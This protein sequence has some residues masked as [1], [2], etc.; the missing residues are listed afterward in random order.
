MINIFNA[1]PLW[2]P[3]RHTFNLGFENKLTTDFFRL[4]PFMVKEALPDDVWKIRPEIFA[5]VSPM[6][7]PVMHRFNI[8]AYFFFVPNR[9]IWDQFEAWINPKS[10]VSDIVSPR[11]VFKSSGLGYMAPKSLADYLG[12]NVGLAPED[13]S[14]YEVFASHITQIFGEDGLTVSALPFRAYQKVFQDWFIDRNNMD[15]LDID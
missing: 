6:L 4:T 8:R 9:I 5:R 1:I 13:Q 11:I 15:D 14:S 2:K 10:G 7:A 12:L 3:K